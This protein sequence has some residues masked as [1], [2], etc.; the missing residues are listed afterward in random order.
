VTRA[1]GLAVILSSV[2]ALAAD[3]VAHE[4]QGWL[5]FFGTKQ[6][7][8]SPW[9]FWLDAQLRLNEHVTQGTV[10]LRPGVGVRFRPDMVAWLGYAWTPVIREGALSLDEHRLWQQW[11]WDVPLPLGMKLSLRSRLEERLALSQVGLRFRQFVRLQSPRLG[12]GPMILAVWD[13]AFIAFNDTSFGQQ[14]GFDQ[15]RAFAGVGLFMSKEVRLEA[16]YLN[17]YQVRRNAPDPMRH[18]LQV[19]VFANW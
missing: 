14:A 6:L 10:L 17:Q 13:E 7:A 16:G 18:V 8:A 15:N 11:T 12:G 4:Q 2:G 3:D 9:V 5:A 1:L 19:S